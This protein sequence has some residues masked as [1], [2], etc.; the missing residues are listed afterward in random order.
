MIFCFTLVSKGIGNIC[1]T[2]DVYACS[3]LSAVIMRNWEILPFEGFRHKL[4]C[5]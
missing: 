3:N 2:C 5:V 4:R 1:W